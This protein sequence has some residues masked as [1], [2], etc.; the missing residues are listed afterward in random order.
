MVTKVEPIEE[1][2]KKFWGWCGFRS[3]AM[4]LSEGGWNYPDGNW[5]IRLPNLDLNNLFKY[6]KPAFIQKYGEGQWANLLHRWI[7]TMYQN[8]SIDP[9]L[10]LFWEVIYGN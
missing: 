1:Q 5:D 10:A 7:D 3:N 4:K 2:I 9:A 8:P 6:A